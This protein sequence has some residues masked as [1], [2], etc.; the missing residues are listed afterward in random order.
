MFLLACQSENLGKTY[1]LDLSHYQ[2]D[3]D[4][5]KVKSWNGHDIQF[6]YIKATEGSDLLDAKYAYNIREAKKNNH[7]VGS[8]HFFRTTSS[9]KDQFEFFKKKVAKDKQDLIPMIDIED[10]KKNLSSKVFNERLQEFLFLIEEYY[11]RKP[12]LYSTQRFYNTYLKDK[13]LNY[14]WSIAR[15]NT[16][17]PNLLDSN[18]WTLWQFTNKGIVDGIPTHVDGKPAGLDVNVLNEDHELD[19]LILNKSLYAQVLLFFKDVLD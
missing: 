13:Y 5:T 7:M 6:V 2:G 3:I 17:P 9:V 12:L 1:G 11:G 18:K 14:Y 4:W 10:N 16:I 19:Y 8:Y 15:Y